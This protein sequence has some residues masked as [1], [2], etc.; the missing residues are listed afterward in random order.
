MIPIEPRWLLEFELAGWLFGDNDDFLGTIREQD[1]LFAGEVH[2]I[3]RFRPGFWASLD[4]N[5]Y[6]I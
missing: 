5:F 3:R 6:T 4:L 2:L 1:P